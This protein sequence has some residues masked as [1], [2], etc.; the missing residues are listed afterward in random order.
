VPVTGSEPHPGDQFGEYRVGDLLGEGAMGAVYRAR[1][2]G[3]DE[4]VALK[5]IKAEF[6]ADDQYRQRFLH[7]ARAAATVD[8]PH[9]IGVIDAGEAGGR[10][11]L[12]MH[13]ASGQSLDKRIAESG[14]LSAQE[15]VCLAE[16]IGGALDALHAAG[17]V[18]RDVKPANIL[19]R[20]GE[21]GAALTDFGLAKGTG[22]ADLTADGQV[23]GSLDY[24]APERIRGEQA[25]PASDMYALGCV[26]IE[27]LVGHPP[28]GGGG[29]VKTLFGHLES[30]P[31]DPG[32]ERDDLSGEFCIAVQAAMAKA[33]EDRPAS[34]TEYSAS[35][36]EAL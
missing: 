21:A 4:D 30:P 8:H 1:R 20:E 2:D 36:R 32:V 22:Y 34:G 18:H 3:A 29:M 27:C 23:V 25:V 19:L 28:F 11:F 9:L 15:T 17:V 13:L 10:Q 26:L 33:A 5:I 7:E 24:L 6:A 31:P 35:L 14:P 12:A 16:E